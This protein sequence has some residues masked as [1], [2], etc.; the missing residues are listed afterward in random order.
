MFADLEEESVDATPESPD[1][2]IAWAIWAKSEAS[3]L[4]ADEGWALLHQRY[5]DEQRFLLLASYAE[6]SEQ[7]RQSKSRL[8][9]GAARPEKQS[10]A[11][12]LAKAE[13]LAASAGAELRPAVREL[14]VF[15]GAVLAGARGPDAARVIA[16]RELLADE[17]AA[18]DDPEA[19]TREPTRD[20]RDRAGLRLRR[21]EREVLREIDE[22]TS[23]G[24]PLGVAVAAPPPRDPKDDWAAAVSDTTKPRRSYAAT[25]RFVRGELVVHPKFGVGLV[26]GTEPGKV[27]LL[28][29]S[30]T[31][32]LVAG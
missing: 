31:R 10:A 23:G 27:H 22:R 3:Q 16:L 8:A 21:L 29:E 2:V 15:G 26:T 14:V 17:G 25:E 20:E 18:D 9:V 7:K 28:F 13:R 1:R 4:A 12:F 11:D 32:K 24:A 6:L 5:P 30:G 19:R